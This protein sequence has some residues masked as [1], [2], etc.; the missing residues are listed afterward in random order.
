MALDFDLENIKIVEF[1]VGRDDGGNR[2][3]S[4]IP[5]D[6]GVQAALRQMVQETWRAMQTLTQFPRRYEP[7]EKYE[8][9][10]YVFLPLDHDLAD[11]MR[12][13]HQAANIDPDSGALADPTTVFCYF[14]RIIDG[15]DR[16]LTAVR[17]ATQFKGV[18]RSRLLRLVTDALKLVED[19]VFKL[20]TDFDLLIDSQRVHILR[21]SGFEFVSKVKQAVLDAVPKIVKA[22]EQDMPFIDF[23][24]I[25]DY[26]AI[27]PRAARYLASIRGQKENRNIDPEALAKLCTR[28]GVEIEVAEGKISVAKGHEM[29]FLEVLERRRYELELI[30]GWPER[31]RATGRE[32]IES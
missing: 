17:R 15:S 8:S 16:H 1:G 10:E 20:D 27:H 3:F 19:R 24:S 9:C 14:A 6:R 18:L 32:K 11:L 28:T 31:F 12:Q 4:L 13:L 7:S 5:V 21:P 2:T 29:G 22:I 30:R 26:A 25:Q 23:A